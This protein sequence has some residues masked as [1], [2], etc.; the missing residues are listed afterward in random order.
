ME[1][2]EKILAYKTWTP[3]QDT[4]VRIT[5][6]KKKRKIQNVYIKKEKTVLLHD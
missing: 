4:N 2:N 6:S 1:E 3:L 5:F